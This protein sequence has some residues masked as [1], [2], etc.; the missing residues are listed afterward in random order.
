[1]QFYGY[2]VNYDPEKFMSAFRSLTYNSLYLSV[3]K[4][5]ATI[6]NLS[7]TDKEKISVTVTLIGMLC[8]IKLQ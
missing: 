7:N 6:L 1:M 2:G 5:Q 8:V 3:K 4:Q